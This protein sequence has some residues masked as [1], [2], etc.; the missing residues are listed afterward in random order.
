[1]SRAGKDHRRRFAELEA[2]IRTLSPATLILD[3]EVAIYDRQLV[4]RFEW[5]RHDAPDGLATKI[6]SPVPGTVKLSE[7]GSPSSS[8]SASLPAHHKEPAETPTAQ[9]PLAEMKLFP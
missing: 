8:F 3:G 5:V 4:S 2:A 9:L 6:G 7:A 1:M